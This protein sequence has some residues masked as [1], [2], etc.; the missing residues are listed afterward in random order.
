MSLRTLL[1]TAA[2][3][4]ALFF[5]GVVHAGAD[6]YAFEPVQSEVDKGDGVTISVRLIEKA[7][8]KPVPDAVI[9]A[10]RIDMAPDNMPTML[11][12]IASLPGDEPGVYRFKTDL[13]MAGRW[14]L[15]LAAKIQGEQETV[16]GEVIFT[17]KP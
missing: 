5:P 7:T 12:P 2:F 15:S 6:D 8:N 4:A 13:V 17:A 14:R 9:I 11:A 3:A 16:K 1:V 10:T